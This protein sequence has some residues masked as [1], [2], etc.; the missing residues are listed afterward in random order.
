[1]ILNEALNPIP[2]LFSTMDGFTGL[3]GSVTGVFCGKADVGVHSSEFFL[4]VIF[5]LDQEVVM[6]ITHALLRFV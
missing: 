4:V 1:M 2:M 6:H 5:S 3:S